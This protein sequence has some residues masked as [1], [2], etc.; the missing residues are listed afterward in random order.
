[1]KGAYCLL[2][3]LSDQARL[4]QQMLLQKCIESPKLHC[5]V[6]FKERLLEKNTYH[7]T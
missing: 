1:M 5:F 4:A 7:R 3:Q 6:D 2:Y